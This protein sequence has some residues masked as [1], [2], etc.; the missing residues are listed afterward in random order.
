MSDSKIGERFI[1][2]EGY[3]LVIVEYNNYNDL[4]I[5]FQDEHKHKKHTTYGNCVDGKVKNP[6]H[7]SVFN[8]GYIGVGDYKSRINNKVTK[9]YK[10]WQNMLERGYGES[11]KK[12]R[13]TYKDVY[14]CEEWHNFQEFAKWFDENYYEIEGETM[15]LDKDILYKN[16]KEYAPDKCIFVPTRI[17]TLFVKSDNIRGDLPIGVSYHKKNNN[18]NVKCSILTED[19][20]KINKHLGCYDTPHEAFLAYK[21]FKEQYIKEIADEYKD[22]IPQELYDAMHRWIV[23]EDD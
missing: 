4:W 18:Y 22:R 13:P 9:Q 11:F 2:N 17:N 1:S 7:P 20:T 16:N 14:V 10:Y 21:E 19:G 3:E 6:Y 12:K 5:Q 15:C 23:E 8:T